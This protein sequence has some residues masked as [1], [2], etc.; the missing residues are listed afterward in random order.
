MPVKVEKGKRKPDSYWLDEYFIIDGKAFNAFSRY[1]GTE[2]EI[3]EQLK[4]DKKAAVLEK[5]ATRHTRI[6]I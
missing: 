5:P 1:A 3:K 2:E 4:K 6:K